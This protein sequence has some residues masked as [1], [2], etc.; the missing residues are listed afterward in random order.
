M[1]NHAVGTEDSTLP[2]SNLVGFCIAMNNQPLTAI[3]LAGGQSSRMGRD[4]ALIS[5]QG[6]PLIR[7]VCEVALV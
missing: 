1:G 5:I 3:V 2:L 7:R 4:K 6:M